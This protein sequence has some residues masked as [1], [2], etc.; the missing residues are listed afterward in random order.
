MVRGLVIKWFVNHFKIE[1]LME[2][3]DPYGFIMTK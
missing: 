3:A 2:N 1:K